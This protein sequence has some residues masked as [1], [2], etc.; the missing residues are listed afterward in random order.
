MS[1]S[2]HR[3]LLFALSMAAACLPG[4]VAAQN[5]QPWDMAFGINTFVGGFQFADSLYLSDQ[6]I[7][8][9][10]LALDFG[11]GV[12]IRGYYWKG[13][14]DDYEET[15]PIQGY[16]GELQLD[17]AL[18][19]VVKQFFIGGYG[20]VDFESDYEDEQGR[21]LGNTS[22]VI[23]GA[24]LGFDLARWL[25]LD[26]TVRDYIFDQP[27]IVGE[28]R[29][30]IRYNNV[31]ASAGITVTLGR[32][33]YATPA[34]TVTMVQAPGQVPVAVIP[35]GAVVTQGGEVVAVPNN[36]P[37]E[38]ADIL[39]DT[40]LPATTMAAEQTISDILAREVGYLDTLFPDQ[41]PLG[42]PRDPIQGEQ[43]DSLNA[44]LAPRFHEAFEFLSLYES[45]AL[46]VTLN[47]QLDRYAVTPDSKDQ[48][49]ASARAV[50]DERITA[51]REDGEVFLPR[52]DSLIAWERSERARRNRLSPTMGGSFGNGTQFV[53]GG[54]VG[55]AAPWSPSF[56]IVPEVQVGMGGGGT[57]MLVQGALRYYHPMPTWEPYAGAGIGLM[58]LSSPVGDRSGSSFMFTPVFGVEFH[59]PDGG[60]RLGRA[61]QG[62]FAEY[63]AVDFFDTHRLLV[64]MSWGF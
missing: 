57:S 22:T 56:A 55:F 9:G 58:V 35:A 42:A 16:G 64:G 7:F 43:A 41:A 62:W 13:A 37:P 49:L 32:R 44:L 34:Q 5:V 36:L 52:L 21:T 4:R 59:A 31:L 51:M 38:L 8:G 30:R 60:G 33:K 63:Q 26:V 24:G 48:I 29:P 25:R 17:L 11:R 3:F 28:D 46:L 12:Q 40:S 50:L 2:S 20:V 27:E 53:L 18:F 61:Y 39:A 19:S 23:L 6:N 15:S 10:H 1:R 47:A 14:D 45:A 54:Q